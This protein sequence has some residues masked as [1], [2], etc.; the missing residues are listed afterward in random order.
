MPNEKKTITFDW[1][2]ENKCK[3]KTEITFLPT[4]IY[5][6]KIPAFVLDCLNFGNHEAQCTANTYLHTYSHRNTSFYLNKIKIHGQTDL[7]VLPTQCI[8]Q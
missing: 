3:A 2:L 5:S 1:S 4:P 6:L 8:C 7:S